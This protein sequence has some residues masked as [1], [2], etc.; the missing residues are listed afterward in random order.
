M[1]TKRQREALVEEA[2]IDT[3]VAGDSGLPLELLVGC[4]KR[5]ATVGEQVIHALHIETIAFEE[6]VMQITEFY[7]VVTYG[8]I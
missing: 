3:K 2:I 5:A 4:D 1:G 8:T 7:V 6:V